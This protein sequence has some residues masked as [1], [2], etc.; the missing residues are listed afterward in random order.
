MENGEK[1]H[2]DDDLFDLMWNTLEEERSML[3]TGTYKQKLD[4]KL[5]A[6]Y[7]KEG[8]FKDY[9]QNNNTSYECEKCGLTISS[10]TN[11]VKHQNTARCKA[12]SEEKQQKELADKIVRKVLLWN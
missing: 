8:Y 3:D 11:K 7:R 5:N 1:Q 12:I 9:Y 4:D 6:K 10:K 2:I